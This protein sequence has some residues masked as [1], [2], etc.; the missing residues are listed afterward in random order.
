MFILE[1]DEELTLRMLSIRDAE[2]LFNLID[3]SR[4]YLKEWLPWVAA[5]KT[6]SD[7]EKYIKDSF[8]TYANQTDLR[9]GIFLNEELVGVLSFNEIDLRNKIATIGYWLGKTHQKK[10][11]MTRSVAALIHYGFYTLDLNRIEI[12]AAVENRASQLIPERLNFKKEGHLRQVE[13]L[14]THFVDHY[15]YG[16]LKADYE[17]N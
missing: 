12:R 4:D 13:W 10:G 15:I 8:Y 1:V 9:A 17:S 14:N 5:N 7:S 3:T 2:P 11:I 6:V 16:L